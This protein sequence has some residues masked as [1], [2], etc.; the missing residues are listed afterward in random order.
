M[1]KEEHRPKK[2][3]CSNFCPHSRHEVVPI[4]RT[5]WAALLVSA[6]MRAWVAHCVYDVQQTVI[7]PY[8]KNDEV[9]I[10]CCLP[11]CEYRGFPGDSLE[12]KNVVDK[13]DRPL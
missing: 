11:L 4:P 12:C 6:T 13:R 2:T 8:T 10:P 5:I 7:C 3:G 9:G 1:G